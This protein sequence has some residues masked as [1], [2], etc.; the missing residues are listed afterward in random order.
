VVEPR[1]TRTETETARPVPKERPPTVD[2]DLN[3]PEQRI[4][5]AIAWLEA[6][7]VTD[8]KQPAVAFLAG[9]TYGG[10]AFNNPKGALRGKGLV[11]YKPGDSIAL[12]DEGRAAAVVPDAPLS[13]EELHRRVL[14]QLPKPEQRILQPLLNAYPESLSKAE[15]AAEA[16]YA[17]GAGAFN[18]PCGRLRSLGLIEYPDPGRA[19][20][21]PL[22]FF[23]VPA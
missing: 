21:L 20:A 18:N 5:N 2:G 22:L 17:P 7:G 10:G 3:G 8:P 1:R 16:G 6:I 11:S 23:Q 9:Y 15:L 4:L 14:G 19:V 12:T 13:V